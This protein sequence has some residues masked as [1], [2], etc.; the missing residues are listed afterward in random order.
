MARP[1]RVFTD[2]EI[3]EIKELAPVMTQE[4]LAEYFS[5]TSKTLRDILKRDE[6]VFTAYTR[7]RYKDGVL[8]AKTL[9]D[10]A[11]LD[12]DF[13]SLKLYLSQTLGW[14]EKSRT[15]HTGADGKPIQMDVDTHWTIE[16]ME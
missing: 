2:E 6:R 5:I 1:E 16:V 8:A 4:Q 9:R 10:K 3:E 15:E 7:A 11:I 12:K 14:T 13:P